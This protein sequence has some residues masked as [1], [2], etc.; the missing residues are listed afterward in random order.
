[1]DLAWPAGVVLQVLGAP[2]LPL[3]G[4]GLCSRQEPSGLEPA[5][6]IVS[7]GWQPWG[8]KAARSP[9]VTGRPADWCQASC[10]TPIR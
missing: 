8:L 7:L 5:Q 4:K 1:M 3:P 6:S 9:V 10:L 2:S